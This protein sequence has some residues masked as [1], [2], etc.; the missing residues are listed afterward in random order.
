MKRL[1]ILFTLLAI[2][3]GAQLGGNLEMF[4]NVPALV[5]VMLG[6]VGILVSAHGAR[7]TFRLIVPIGDSFD[8]LENESD[9]A[10]TGITAFVAAGWIGALI[11]VVQLLSALDDPSQ[12]G[13]GVAVALM[14]PFYGHVIAYAFCYP[15]SRRKSG[16]STRI[17][18]S[19]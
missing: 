2:G 15:L 10:K 8:Q 9:I 13:A 14:S 4:V 6:G 19:I 16:L 18:Q 5:F 11:G 7:A 12:L 1:G 3:L 17:Q